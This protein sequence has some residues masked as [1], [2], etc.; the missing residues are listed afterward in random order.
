MY[1]RDEE[2][3]EEKLD[4]ENQDKQSATT[5]KQPSPAPK[6]LKRPVSSEI[7]QKKSF[8]DKQIELNEKLALK[9]NVMSLYNANVALFSIVGLLIIPYILGFVFTYLLFAFYGGMSIGGFISIDKAYLPF[10]LWSMG[11]YMLI[12]VWVIWAVLSIFKSDE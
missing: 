5:V 10:Q 6:K 7:E 9:K 8:Q 2:I 4:W 1:K 11:A 12:T 3:A